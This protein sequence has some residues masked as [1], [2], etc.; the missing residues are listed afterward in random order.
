MGES[1][2]TSEIKSERESGKLTALLQQKFPNA[3][4]DFHSH[5]LDETVVIERDSL[6]KVCQFLRDDSRCAFEIMIDLTAVD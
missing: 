6:G 3:V 1:I 5:R 2:K 4:L